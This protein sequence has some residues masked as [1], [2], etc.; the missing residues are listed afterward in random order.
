MIN[1]E[2]PGWPIY[3]EEQIEAVAHVLRSGNVNYLSGVEG[4]A[5][6]SEFAQY[7]GVR[8][9]IAVS[10]G[11][12]ALELA[13]RALGVG[14]GD[15]VIV[16]P[17][18]FIASASAIVMVG[19]KPVFADIDPDSQN[20]T[21]ET[22]AEVLSP[23]TKAIIVVHLAGWPCDMDTIIELAR[24]HNIR[25]I[26]DCAQAHGATYKGRKVGSLGDVATFSFCQ[27]KIMSTGGEGGMVTT[28]SEELWRRIWSFKDHGKNYDAVYNMKHPPGFRWL[29]ESF[30]S[31]YRMTELQAA[32]GRYQLRKLD[33]WLARRRANAAILTREIADTPCIRVPHLPDD[34]SHAF[35]KFYFFVEPDMLE[36]GWSRDRI[37]VEVTDR[38]IPCFS[39]SCS[40]IYREKAFENTGFIPKKRLPVAQQLGETSLLLLVHP[41]IH[42]AHMMSASKVV[43]DVLDRATK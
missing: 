38:G 41:T 6:E 42:D 28:D 24:K 31:N 21:A 8:Y 25:T 33:E 23:K 30:G 14:E 37:M 12:T 2:F 35:Y 29:H 34:I 16:T 3:D 4:R 1:S 9:A 7:C 15:E 26:E 17:R 39:G 40:E 11:T 19:A 20:I 43:R 22:I 32:L 27:D 18:T 5:F 10:N 36:E 13:L